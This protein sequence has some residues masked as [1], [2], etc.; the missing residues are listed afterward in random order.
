MSAPRAPQQ[1]TVHNNCGERA[2]GKVLTRLLPFAMLLLFVN[3]LD[4]SNIS[5]AALQMNEDLGFTPA[6]YG[7][8]AGVFFLGY[9][10]FELPSNLILARVGGRLWLARIAISWGLVAMAMGWVNTATSLYI[11]RFL[12][13]VAEAGLLPGLLYF[14]SLWIPGAQRAFAYSLLL[15]ITAVASILGGPIATG[16]MELDGLGGFRGWQ[17]VFVVEGIAT[18]TLGLVTLRVLPDTPLQARWLDPS[19]Q[20]W[21]TETIAAEHAAKSRTGAT[22]LRQG[23]LD[24]RV[25]M[26]TVV[27]FFFVCCNFGTVFWLPQIIKSL[28]DLTNLQVGAISAIPYMLGGMAMVLWGRHSDRSGDRKWH[29]AGSAAVASVAYLWAALAP[30]SEHSFIALCVATAAIWSMFGVFWA[31]T[32]DLLGGIA[33]AAGMAVI[34]SF[35][36]LGGFV[37]P[38]LIGF[39]KERTQS[40][41]GGLL[42]LAAFAGITA[43]LAIFLRN[44]GTEQECTTAASRSARQNSTAH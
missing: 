37:G 14:L 23:L 38:Y 3:L 25:L 15:S 4:R 34:N 22:T 32:G 12:L 19:E 35:A 16:L 29:L 40:F 8:A 44:Y 6:V 30:T 28:G 39:L 43:V 21:L 7:F 26:I 42:A 18:I 10:L 41:T 24:R 20:R 9:F 1:T 31:L 5:Y 2:V 33:A 17:L 13:G 36:S 11:A 27:S